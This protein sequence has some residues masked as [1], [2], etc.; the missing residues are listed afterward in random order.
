MAS[1]RPHKGRWTVTVRIPAEFQG[2]V[3][4]RSISETFPKKR[5]A[6][7]WADG[8]ETG[9]KLGTWRDPRLEDRKTSGR[10]EDRP[11]RDTIQRYKDTVTPTKKGAAKEATL[12][13]RWMR[14]EL[15]DRPTRTIARS[16]IATYR[17]ERVRAKK[18]PQTI[19]NEINTLSAVFGY[20]KSDWGYDLENPVRDLLSQRKGVLPKARPGRERRL[21]GDE[22]SRLEKALTEGGDGE[23]MLALWRVL[24]DTGMRLGEALGLTVATVRN[25][26]RSLLLP[27]TKNGTTREVLLSDQAWTDLCDHIRGL[28]D[29]EL[30]FPGQ[31]VVDYRWKLARATAKV[32]GFRIHDL[33]HEA[34]SRMAARGVD[35]KTMM[36][37]SGHKTPA[38][39]MRY[40][41]PT[42][43]ERRLKLFGESSSYFQ[44]Q[45]AA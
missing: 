32:S 17:D 11:L 4:A 16:D 33:R 1:F 2:P 38:M 8:I 20:A 6:Q 10:C 44:H 13:E 36:S 24:L 27:D 34:L 23:G 14:H 35:I 40:L 45:V 9:I 3:A 39:L 25:G 19:R 30:L 37:Q 15:A 7:T 18:A 43:E 26:E 21:V 22:Q 41:N 28:D 29:D 12:L 5:E 42:R 31:G